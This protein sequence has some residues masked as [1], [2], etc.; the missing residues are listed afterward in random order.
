MMYDGCDMTDSQK[1]AA[2][3]YKL[4]ADQGWPEVAAL[5]LGTVFMQAG[6]FHCIE[7]Q[8]ECRAK[9]E[10]LIQGAVGGRVW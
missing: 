10:A 4:L 8:E 6:F 9:D 2:R 1:L 5:E 7:M 3:G